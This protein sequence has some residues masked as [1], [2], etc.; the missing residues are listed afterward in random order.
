MTTQESF[1]RRVRQRMAKTG[2]RYAAARRTLIEQAEARAACQ[3]E[4]RRRVWVSE[5]EVGNAA[6]VEGTGRSW[7]DWVDLIE[8]WPDRPEG[9]ADGHPAVAAHLEAAH[10]LDGW[11]AQTV[12]VGF[13][14]IT[15]LRL[16][17]Q[18]PDG[19]FT[20]GK[21]R[22][23]DVDHDALRH[24]L[25]DDDDRRQ[26][27]P[28]QHTELRSKPSAKAIRLAI[29]PGVALISLTPHNTRTKVSVNH[30]RIPTYDEVEEWKFYWTEWLTALE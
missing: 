15:G 4:P 17:Y 24:A 12:T 20:A 27:F 14:R 6:V 2:E 10:H 25:L 11:W 8:A 7:D 26:L 16:P 21:S 19:T 29:G 23:V 9:H 5:P 22:T 1:K 18:R 30:E 13:E 28:G 3:S